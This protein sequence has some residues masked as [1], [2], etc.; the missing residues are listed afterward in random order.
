MDDLRDYIPIAEAH[1]DW[2]LQMIRPL[3]VSYFE[4]GFK[5]GVEKGK[6]EVRDDSK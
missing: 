5:H 2:F 3:L 4:H 1:V 6:E